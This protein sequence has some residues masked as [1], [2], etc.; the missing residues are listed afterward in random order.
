MRKL[1]STLILLLVTAPVFAGNALPFS[2]PE[3][4][5]TSALIGIA[6]LVG[7]LGLIKERSRRK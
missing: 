4:D 3:I 2:V 1:I 7:V 6:V 5:G